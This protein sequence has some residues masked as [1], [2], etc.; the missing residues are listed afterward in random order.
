MWIDLLAHVYQNLSI[1]L[2]DGKVLLCFFQ[3]EKCSL[4]PA[5]HVALMAIYFSIILDSSRYWTIELKVYSF[6]FLLLSEFL[7]YDT[8]FNARPSRCGFSS[9]CSL[10]LPLC[11]SSFLCTWIWSQLTRTPESW[12]FVVVLLGENIYFL[13]QFTYYALISL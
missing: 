10:S 3:H 2:V 1:A 13:S 5:F 4:W 8:T 11:S 6:L 9:S 12:H 7:S